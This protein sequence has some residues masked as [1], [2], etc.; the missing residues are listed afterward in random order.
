MD[1]S[2]IERYA[3]GAGAVADAVRGLSNE[4][5]DAIP[6]PGQWSVRQLAVHLLDSDLVGTDRMKRVAAE[7]RPLLMGYDENL[8]LSNLPIKSLDLRLVGEAFRV[9]REAT[10]AILRG[11]PGEAFDRVGIHSERGL[12]TL[13]GLVED[14][15]AHLDHHLGFMKTK[16]AALKRGSQVR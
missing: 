7:R 4:Q 16:L 15:V 6:V 8:F 3:S 13:G 11:L 12:V 1:R 10:A 9:N 2:L 5:A 14:Y